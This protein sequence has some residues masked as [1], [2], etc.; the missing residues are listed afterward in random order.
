MDAAVRE[1]MRDAGSVYVIDQAALGELRPDLILTQAVCDVCAVPAADARLAA[2]ALG[3][4]AQVLSL[5]AHTMSGILET[6]RQVGEATDAQGAAERFAAELTSR[7]DRVRERVAGLPAPGVLGLEWLDPPF[8]PGHWVPE[9][10]EIAG[11]RNLAGTIGARSIEASWEELAR[12][13]PDVLLVMP[14]G[15]DLE[16]ARRDADRYAERLQSVAPRA[17]AEGRA[18]VVDASSY[19]N[20]SGPRVVDGVEI[21]AK[22]LHPERFA[23]VELEGRGARWEPAS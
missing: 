15:Y 18:F 7:L 1:A 17:L 21:L 22:L 12:L 10:V 2:E 6:I 4:G 11:G 5:D 16:A 13:E 19:F 3:P 9:M 8:V 14:C 23:D 20:R